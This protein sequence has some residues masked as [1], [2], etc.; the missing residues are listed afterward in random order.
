MITPHRAIAPSRH[1]P[2]QLSTERIGS[3]G[4]HPLGLDAALARRVEAK[5]VHHDVPN[6]G[7][8]VGGVS[9][10][11]GGLVLAEL[12]VETP[13]KA[14]FD[15]PMAAHRVRNPRGIR[16]QGAEVVAPLTARFCADGP[17]A[18]DDR[19]ALQICPLVGLVEVIDRIARPATSHFRSTVPLFTALRDGTCRQCAAHAWLGEQEG[20]D[21]FGMVVLHAQ[22]VVGA[23]L[24]DRLRNAGLG[25]HRVDSDDT[26][27]ELQRRQQFGNRRDLVG[28]LGRRD[29]TEHEAD[30]RGEGADQVERTRRRLGRAAP[31]GLLING[32][33]RILA[34]GRNQLPD[35]ASKG[36]FEL[37]WIER[38]KDASK[39]VMGGNP[40]L[41]HQKASQPV[42]RFL[43]PRLD[44]G[45]FV[46]AAQHGAH[47]DREQLGQIVPDL[48]DAA[49]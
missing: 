10:A 25:A 41:K 9:R 40:V 11:H 7:E 32:D 24:T 36:G 14:V 2:E 44:V 13:M 48:P 30:V 29:L 5:Q 37:A 17:L 46:R 27:L 3:G 18:L 47:R 31:A 38:S 23:T 16:R 12:D 33:D 6:D 22:H 35:P 8:V 39:R 43:G 28:L 15:L 34:K 45:E 21:E 1:E 19:K 49:W 20:F 42:D 26:A 4:Q